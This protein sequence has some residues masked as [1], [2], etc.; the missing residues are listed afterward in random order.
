MGLML[1]CACSDTASRTRA[2]EAE[3]WGCSG[4]KRV[5]W[6]SRDWQGNSGKGRLS[7]IVGKE[8]VNAF[9]ELNLTEGLQFERRIYS[10]PTTKKK[11]STTSVPFPSALL[12][13]NRNGNICGE[14]DN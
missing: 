12:N 11:V 8:A 4:G 5:G 14:E 1:F 10:L 13:M 7:V 6:N 2:D 9:Y 3:A